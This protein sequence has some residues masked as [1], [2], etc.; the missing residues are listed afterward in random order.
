MRPEDFPNFDAHSWSWNWLSINL[1]VSPNIRPA[2]MDGYIHQNGELLLLDGKVTRS[3]PEPSTP[4]RNMICDMGNVTLLIVHTHPDD[5]DYETRQPDRIA[6]Y[7]I[8]PSAQMR[9][10]PLEYTYRA[11]VPFK[12]ELSDRQTV[13]AMRSLIVVWTTLAGALV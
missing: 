1:G 10:W 3:R 9:N 6:G 7:S 4:Q 2:D 5:W 13:D 8:W 11:Y 12:K